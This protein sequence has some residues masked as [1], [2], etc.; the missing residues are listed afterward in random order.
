MTHSDTEVEV[1]DP[2]SLPRFRRAL[3]LVLAFY[4]TARCMSFAVPIM[5]GIRP[6]AVPEIIESTVS[7]Q[8]WAILWGAGALLHFAAL[9]WDWAGR[10]TM[11]T[12]SIKG[13]AVGAAFVISA[14]VADGSIPA[15]IGG[16]VSYGFPVVMLWL[17]QWALA[18]RTTVIVKSIPVVEAH[19]VASAARDRLRAVT[20]E[21]PEVPHG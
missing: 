4:A 19:A 15:S 9:R 2:P 7:L 13:L 10:A 3:F 1:K 21:I 11:W 6:A 17:V 14:I 16:I 12:F 8:A 18:M 20:G 5:F